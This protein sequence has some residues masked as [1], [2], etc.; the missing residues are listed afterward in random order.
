MNKIAMLL[1]LL[2][3]AFPATGVAHEMTEKYIPVGQYTSVRGPDTHHG[4]IASTD[5]GQQTVTITTDTGD[6]TYAVTESTR[7]WVDRSL[8]KEP[9]L[10]GSLEDIRP[11]LKAEIRTAHSNPK[12]AYWIKV[13]LA[14]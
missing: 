4:Q 13:Q 5:A 2:F 11:G 3:T 12:Q 10:D 14:P 9:N 7:I 1:M 6:H 8:R